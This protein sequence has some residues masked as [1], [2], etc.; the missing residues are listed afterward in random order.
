[1]PTGKK[2]ASDSGFAVVDFSDLFCEQDA[3]RQTKMKIKV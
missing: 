1:L 2:L 3:I